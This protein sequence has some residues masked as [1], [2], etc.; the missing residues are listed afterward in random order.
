MEATIIKICRKCGEEKP[1]DKFT[2][3]KKCKNG[4]SH[5]CI[6]CTNEIKKEWIKNNPEKDKIHKV[7]ARKKY[8]INNKEKCTE[9]FLKW[10]KENP[11]KYK[12]SLSKSR[13]K[14]RQN[15]VNHAVKTH[16][17]VSF[18]IPFKD[19]VNLSNELIEAKRQ[20]ILLFREKKKQKQLQTI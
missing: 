17:S 5:R 20:N 14:A 19:L 18:N 15:L 1:L 10:K 6:K 2:K 8:R 3:D 12:E 9:S 4:C 11:N 16:I 7:K 13:L